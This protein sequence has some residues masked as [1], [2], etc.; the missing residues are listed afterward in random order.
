MTLFLLLALIT[1][2]V[3]RLISAENPLRPHSANFAGKMP[4]Q[5]EQVVNIVNRFLHE[6][7]A[8][9]LEIAIPA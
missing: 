7:A 8:G 2:Q 5:E 6:H 4:G 1:T 9:L 3:K